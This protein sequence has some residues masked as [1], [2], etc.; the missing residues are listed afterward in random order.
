MFSLT[1]K[2]LSEGTSGYVALEQRIL[3]PQKGTI[4]RHVGSY[5]VSIAGNGARQV[6]RLGMQ[7]AKW[8]S[9]VMTPMV[10]V[11]GVY[12]LIWNFCE[13]LEDDR[14]WANAV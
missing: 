13:K 9:I 12:R 1:R 2:V 3:L 6:M 7:K 10:L 8:F 14:H 4:Y 5:D 11:G